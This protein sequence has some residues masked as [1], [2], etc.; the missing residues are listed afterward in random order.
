[1]DTLIFRNDDVNPNTNYAELFECYKVIKELFPSCEIVSG[2]TLF[3][4]TSNKGSVYPGVPFK[5]KPVDWFYNV[6]RFMDDLELIQFGKL[7]SHGLFHVDHS[8]ISYDAQEMS[9]ISSCRFLGTD[10]FIPPFNRWNDDTIKI[11]DD[12]ALNLISMKGQW[13]S[14]E[15]EIFNSNHPFWYFHSWRFNVKELREVLNNGTCSESNNS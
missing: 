14:F 3:S 6:D 12:Y 9:I 4:K 2:V 8:K 11:C 7:A 15:Y 10:L 5:D 1:M 13:K